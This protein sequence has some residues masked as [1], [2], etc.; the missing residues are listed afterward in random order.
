MA[1][2]TY[3]FDVPEEYADDVVSVEVKMLTLDEESMANKRGGSDNTKTAHELTKASL[4]SATRKVEGGES[5]IKLGIGDG[6]VDTFWKEI[7]SPVRQLIASDTAA[8]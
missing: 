1:K 8:A 4:V 2:I 6:S 5:V 7:S 3:E